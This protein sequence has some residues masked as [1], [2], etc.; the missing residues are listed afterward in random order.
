LCA[1]GRLDIEHSLTRNSGCRLE[2]I[3]HY[4]SVLTFADVLGSDLTASAHRHLIPNDI[5]RTP[6]ASCLQKCDVS[7]DAAAAAMMVN[8]KLGRQPLKR[9]LHLTI[10]DQIAEGTCA[11]RCSEMLTFARASPTPVL[12]R[13]RLESDAVRRSC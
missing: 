2:V 6:A 12:G 13:C 7:S 3:A 9:I 11:R 1:Q 8:L 10:E 5:A 4:G